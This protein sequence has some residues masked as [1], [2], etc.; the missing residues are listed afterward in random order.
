MKRRVRIKVRGE[1]GKVVEM[2]FL[3]WGKRWVGE[4]GVGKLVDCEKGEV[5]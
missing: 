5:L 4:M 2:K 1:G 3:I